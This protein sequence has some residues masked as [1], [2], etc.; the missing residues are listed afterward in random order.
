MSEGKQA[1]FGISSGLTIGGTVLACI[2]CPAMTPFIIVGG[3]VAGTVLAKKAADEDASRSK[4]LE[5]KEVDMLPTPTRRTPLSDYDPC[6]SSLLT[7]SS[8]IPENP[9][10]EL[11]K[12]APRLS[13]NALLIHSLDEV[14][15]GIVGPAAAEFAR[16]GRGTRAI[17]RRGLFSRSIETIITPIDK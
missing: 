14:H 8:F 2:A 10:T 3:V 11:A 16:Q 17:T 7:T 15:E 4:S 13:Y 1:F 5:R 9:V 6:F 12:R